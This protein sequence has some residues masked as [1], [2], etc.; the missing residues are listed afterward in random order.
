MSDVAATAAAKHAAEMHQGR[1][2]RNRLPWPFFWALSALIGSRLPESGR[3]RRACLLIPKNSS[4]IRCEGLAHDGLEGLIREKI[5][6]CQS[7]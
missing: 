1:G 6:H 2:R 4:S 5:C 3:S 7:H